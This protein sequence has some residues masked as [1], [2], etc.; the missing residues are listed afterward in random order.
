[1]M[2]SPYD[3]NARAMINMEAR[4]GSGGQI[5]TDNMSVVPNQSNMHTLQPVVVDSG[6]S[7]LMSMDP[8]TG[9]IVP[10]LNAMMMMMMPQAGAQYPVMFTS[11][12]PMSLADKMT[13]EGFTHMMSMAGNTQPVMGVHSTIDVKQLSSLQG[14]ADSWMKPN[15]A[16]GISPVQLA[17]S[18]VNPQEPEVKHPNPPKRPLS[19]YMRFSK[20]VNK[21]I[22]HFIDSY[23]SRIVLLVFC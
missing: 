9:Q 16:V 21:H 20:Q 8:S 4:V 11:S 18:K 3:Q 2:T 14:N 5:L 23:E 6:W 10:T 22:S 19:A 17:E 13:S 15:R 12:Q 1:M 7:S